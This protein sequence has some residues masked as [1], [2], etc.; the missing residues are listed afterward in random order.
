[1]KLLFEAIIKFSLGVI[2]VGVMLFLPAGTLDY[3][4]A[5]LFMG[6]LFV[7]MFCAGIVMMM[8]SPD[9]LRRRLDAKEKQSSQ[10][11]VIALSGLM[12]PFGFV[13]SAL[14]FRFAWSLVPMWLVALS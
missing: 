12:F 13:L 7:P 10:K 4:L 11:G 9:L 14:D 2:L 8:R 5:W 3:P 1:M 6:L